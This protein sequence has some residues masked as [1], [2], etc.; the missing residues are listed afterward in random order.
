MCQKGLVKWLKGVMVDKGEEE[1]STRRKDTD[2]ALGAVE[3]GN[4]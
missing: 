1:R 3:H 4:S 2:E